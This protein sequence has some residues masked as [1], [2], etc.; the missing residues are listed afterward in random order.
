MWKDESQVHVSNPIFYISGSKTFCFYVNIQNH[1][2]FSLSGIA[3]CVM[4]YTRLD[5]NHKIEAGDTV[6]VSN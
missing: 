3:I 1:I 4:H 5:S 6:P 2:F